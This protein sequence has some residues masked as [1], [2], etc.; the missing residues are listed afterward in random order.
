MHAPAAIECR[1]PFL[2]V[3]FVEPQCCLSWALVRGG[4][5]R[6][7]T[8]AWYYV[9]PSEY[10]HLDEAAAFLEAKLHGIGVYGAV[11]LMTSRRRYGHVESIA[12]REGSSAWCLT[13]VGLKNALRCG[14]NG[15]H[16]PPAATINTL[17]WISQPLADSAMI[18]A[19]AMVAEARTAAVLDARVASSVSG[20]PSTGTGTDCVVVACPAH[21]PRAV[22]TGKHTVAGSLIGRAVYDAVSRGVA[23]WIE[24]HG[25]H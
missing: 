18:E 10:E 20:E 8:V 13:T 14:D 19:V 5:V 12:S 7:S 3:R 9:E 17:C 15:S 21:E 2:L 23:D 16:L 6:A 11:G 4:R 25:L 24:H 22:Y 1:G